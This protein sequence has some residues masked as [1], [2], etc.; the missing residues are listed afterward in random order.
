MSAFAASKI[1][2]KMQQE[3]DFPTLDLFAGAYIMGTV[4][5]TISLTD[6]EDAWIKEQIDAGRS[7]N[8]REYIRAQI[9]REQEHSVELDHIR[10]AL[11][12]G[13]ASGEAQPFDASAFKKRMLAAHG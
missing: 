3:H 12:E 10:A 11:L 7:A 5:K 2:A 4:R 13:E 1:C 6:Q 9:R 8:D